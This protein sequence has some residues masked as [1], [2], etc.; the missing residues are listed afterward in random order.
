MSTSNFRS[1]VLHG[2]AANRTP[3]FHFA[4]NFLGVA[5]DRVSADGA[6]ISLESLPHL[7]DARG[8]MDLGTVAMVADIALA[9]SVRVALAS[10]RARLAT[11]SM[12]LQFTGAPI[13]GRLDARGEFQGFL[14]GTGARQG[15]SRVALD[16]NGTR[17]AFGTGAFMALD[18]PP[19]VTM[20]PV[21][22]ERPKDT[23]PLDE[24]TLEGHEAEILRHADGVIARLQ[25]A[26]SL[27]EAFWGYQA[28]R[29]EAG[30]S[31]T[32]KNG[33]HVSNR[34]GHVQGGLLVGLGARTAMAALPENW[35]LA[36]V[37][38]CFVSPGE[39]PSLHAS[40]RIIHQGRD[41]AVLRTEVIGTDER[42]VLQVMT[43][44]ARRPAA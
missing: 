1:R 24:T 38:A 16:V 35:M 40:S 20:H 36:S 4:G 7:V 23:S 34:V 12:H 18:P 30:S 8:E 21:V 15:V 44:H 37:T 33:G 2:L 19:G 27:I 22:P 17:V 39:G 5:F 6:H 25:A 42:K 14:T 31:A 11:V 3:G 32:M 9:T 28:H 41:T 10:D 29:T 13:V 43:T 26:E